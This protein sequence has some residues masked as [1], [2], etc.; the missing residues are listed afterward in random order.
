M[1]L[2]LH[3]EKKLGFIHIVKNGGIFIGSLLLHLYGFKQDKGMTPLSI[4]IKN[5]YIKKKNFSENEKKK[6]TINMKET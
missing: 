1:S 6:I 4:D 3:D 2:Y 5:Y